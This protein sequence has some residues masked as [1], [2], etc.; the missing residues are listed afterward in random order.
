MVIED[1][2]VDEEY[3]RE[4]LHF[5]ATTFIEHP[6]TATRLHFFAANEDCV[7]ALLD[8]LGQGSPDAEEAYLGYAVLRPTA[9]PTV[10]ETLLRVPGTLAGQQCYTHCATSFGQTLLG[11]R[12]R[13]PAAPFI[14]QDQTGVCAH[15][16]IWER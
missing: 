9:P 2:V 4:Y 8:P 7:R 1:H 3:F 5:Y 10:G 13:V 11:R 6:S 16:A 14:G 15:S 12:L